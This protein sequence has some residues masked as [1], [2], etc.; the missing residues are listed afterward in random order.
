MKSADIG[1]S[2]DTAVDVAKE[3]A[4]IIPFGKGFDGFGAG[5]HR[6]AQNLCEY[7]EVYQNDSIF[8]FRQYV[9]GIGGICTA[10][11]PADD[12]RAFDFPE[13]DL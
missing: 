2:V 5:N 11:L 6:G 1:I 10:A 13:F 4:D 7:D 12:E 3:S 9:F 8:Q